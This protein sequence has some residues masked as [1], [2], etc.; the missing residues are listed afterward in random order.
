M[1]VVMGG[2]S[3]EG[4]LTGIGHYTYNLA[5]QLLKSGEIESLDFLVHGRIKGP[6][7]L[8][9]HSTAAPESD[10]KD[11]GDFDAND[12][13]D[14]RGRAW[15]AD[16]LG[17]AR[18]IAA[19]S[20]VAVNLYERAI[21]AMERRCLRAYGRDDIFHSP[22]Y[23]LPEF[24]GHT[25]VSILDLST[26]RYPE[27]HPEA[28]V[29]FVNR[30]IERSVAQADHII[31]I[32]EFI[33]A[34]IVERFRLP[35]ARISVT[36]LG[37]N[38]GF[39]PRSAESVTEQLQRFA[40][41]LRYKNYFLFTSSIEPRKNLDRIIDA[42]LAYREGTSGDALPLVVTGAAGWKSQHTHSRLAS[43]QRQ[44]L[45]LH[46]GYI[47]QEMLPFLVAGARA[48]V[49][50]SLYEGF[51]LP[52]LEAMQSGTATLTSRDSAMAEVAGDAS[53]L[54]LSLIHI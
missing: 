5:S 31:T 6:D 33:K 30:H 10:N 32:S 24:P 35:E 52:V 43:L 22:N 21:P 53:L 26:Y 20:T 13:A 50:P 18:S 34:E 9:R 8:N 46:L 36:H 1:R 45:L 44:G 48:V 47:S 11:A 54:V 39:H 25:V 2:E 40:P 49:Y 37:A 28:R 23:M 51:G 19:K 7:F 16:A 17:K 3:L 41:N 27:H 4:P 38:Q 15:I 14:Q 42:Y 29:R 12:S